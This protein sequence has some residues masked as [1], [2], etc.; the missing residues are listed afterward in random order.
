MKTLE[1]EWCIVI[2]AYKLTI[3]EIWRIFCT[4]MYCVFALSLRTV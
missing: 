3:F 1:H 2:K 4:I